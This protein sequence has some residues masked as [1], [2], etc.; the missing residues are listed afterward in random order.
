M[1]RIMGWPMGVLP[2]G[3]NK[4][5]AKEEGAAQ[6]SAV[7]AHIGAMTFLAPSAPVKMDSLY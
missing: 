7:L 5:A 3:M 1:A 2:Y 6:A 4:L